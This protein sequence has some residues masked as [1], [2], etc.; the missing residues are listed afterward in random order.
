VGTDSRT[1]F[2]VTAKHVFFEPQKGWHPS[3]LSLR[4]AWEE[5]QSITQDLGFPV[6]LTDDGGRDLWTAAANGHDIAAIRVTPGIFSRP[7]PLGQS[8]NAISLGEMG[9]ASDTYDG[10]S[11]LIYGFPGFV[12]PA[13]LVRALTRAGVIAWTNPNDPLNEPF[14]VD[15]NIFPGN[16]GGPVFSVPSGLDRAGGIQLGSHTTLLGIVVANFGAPSDAVAKIAG[17]SSLTKEQI[18]VNGLGSLGVVEPASQI[19]SLIESMAR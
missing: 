16:S 14:L 9:G 3:E 7:A 1:A 18:A 19:R 15:A 17:S 5:R 10:A 12:G 2:L 11:V 13:A 8:Y 4:F 6:R